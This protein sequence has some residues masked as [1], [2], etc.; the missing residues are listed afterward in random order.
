MM[1][2]S[3]FILSFIITAWGIALVGL[4]RRGRRLDDHPICRGCGFDLVGSLP[5][6][7]R[8]GFAVPREA[9]CPECGVALARAVAIEIGNRARRP[10]L[11]AAGFSLAALGIVGLLLT[12]WASSSALGLARYQPTWMLVWRAGADQQAVQELGARIARGTITKSAVQSL[13]ARALKIQARP[14]R[15]SGTRHVPGAISSSR[16]GGP[17]S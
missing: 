6:G 4:G 3:W 1:T 7:R 13:V 8:L 12:A 9:R 15:A 16:P 17:G 10:P 11:I 14:C 5:P 2:G